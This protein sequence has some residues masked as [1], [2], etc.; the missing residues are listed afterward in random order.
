MSDQSP[1]SLK[2][3]SALIFVVILGLASL[4][5]D[6]VYE[7]ARSIVGPFFSTLGATGA[8][9]GFV[10]GFG[11]F[12]GNTLRLLSGY[13]IDRTEKFW[14]TTFLGYSCLFAIPLLA[15]V[16]EWKWAAALLIIERIGKAIRTPARDA[17]LSYATQKIGRGIG[18]GLHQVFDQMGG[19]LGPFIMTMVLL[20]HKDYSLGFSLLIIPVFITLIILAFGK[21]QYPTPKKL[22]VETLEVKSSQIPFIFW[23]YLGGAMLMAAGFADFP[24]IAFHFEKANLL[25]PIWITIF[26]IIAMGMSAFSA[27]LFG[28]LYDRIGV[29]SLLIAIPLSSFFAPCVFYDGFKIA[30]LGMILWGI[31][32]G[33]QRSLLKAIIGD[34]ISKNSRGFAYGIF[35]AGYG[36]AWFLGSWLIGILYDTSL[37]ALVLFSMVSE[38]AAVPFIYWVARKVSNNE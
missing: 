26:Y 37:H 22:E 3:H 9:V 20:F 17:M 15:W 32:M 18:F 8:I 11:E 28:W 13:F 24:L 21:N 31:G 1:P 29:N 14:F 23:V 36:I 35:N 10:A 6:T 7:G 12:I 30:L 19:M 34:M 5:S 2:P 16:H 27:L 33:A 4:F 38:L 25:K